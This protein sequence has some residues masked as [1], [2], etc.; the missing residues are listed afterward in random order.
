M[1]GKIVILQGLQTTVSV[2]E[3]WLLYQI[4]YNTII[5]KQYLK[6]KEICVIWGNI[7]ILGVLSSTNRNLLF[8]SHSMFM[9][10]VVITIFCV[11]IIKR[12]HLALIMGL[13]LTYYSF[14]ALLDFL[15]AF[16]GMSFLGRLFNHTVYFQGMTLEK[17]VI[18]ICS[19]IIGGTIVIAIKKQHHIKMH[20]LE[21][22]NILLVVSI[23]FCVLVRRYQVILA[24][25][26]FRMRQMEGKNTIISLLT[27]I[28]IVS[29]I[30]ILLVKNKIIQK[31]NNFLILQD[32]MERQKY[33]DLSLALEKNREL[34]H[35]IKNHYLVLKEYESTGDYEG[36]SQYL[37]EISKNFV[38]VN[39]QE[40][41]GIRILDLILCQKRIEAERKQIDFELWTKPFS[42][43]SLVDSE[44]CALF[45][46]LLDNAIEACERIDSGER[47][48][49]IR[50]EKQK[51]LFF[52][53]IW[54]TISEVP[55]KK[56]EGFLSSKA[57]RDMH[58]YGLK[59]VKR[60]VDKYDSVISY[61]VE[62]KKFIVSVSFF[63]V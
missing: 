31:E 56:G 47:K 2:F 41:T 6:R 40:H 28:I 35:D 1:T 58:G 25:M 29:F 55:K 52:I 13:T 30:G 21:F 5:E 49:S 36:L 46:N 50:I 3:I 26:V 9:V 63:D 59:S 61:K 43:L 4:L 12:K 44:I 23:M 34:V 51:Y 10:L 45:G 14:I 53:E 38:K 54:N 48:I 20:I 19:R 60:I 15:F 32:E 33:E 22:Q 8:F 11:W 27:M 16:A 39:W 37:E 42:D 7:I 17:L 62:G 18:Y 57:N 24:E